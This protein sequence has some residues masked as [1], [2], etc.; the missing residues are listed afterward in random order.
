[1]ILSVLCRYSAVAND[2]NYLLSGS[3]RSLANDYGRRRMF[4]NVPKYYSWIVPSGIVA[5]EKSAQNKFALPR[6][7]P[8][9][10][11][12]RRSAQ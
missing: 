5:P 8:F 2:R 3:P 11:E 12:P 1:M 7:A 10:L 6:F 4:S 9:K